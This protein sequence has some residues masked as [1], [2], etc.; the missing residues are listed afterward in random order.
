M[1]TGFLESTEHAVDSRYLGPR[2]AGHLPTRIQTLSA[3]RTRGFDF[4]AGPQSKK[5]KTKSGFVKLWGFVFSI[6]LPKF[7]FIRPRIKTK[8]RFKESAQKVSS[9][10][11]F[12]DQKLDPGQSG[13]YLLS[14][15]KKQ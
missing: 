9:W 13:D 1:A 11:S 15:G 8:N 4:L 2:A 10:V 5:M 14:M 6:S 7:I 3:V 12:T